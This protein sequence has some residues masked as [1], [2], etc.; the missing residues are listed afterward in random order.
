MPRKSKKSEKALEQEAIPQTETA[1][2]EATPEVSATAIEDPIGDTTDGEA[3]VY[4][5]E[6]E[7]ATEEV[8]EAL[9][10]EPAED[11]EIES[12]ADEEDGDATESGANG[13]GDPGADA[14]LGDRSG[15]Q[16]KGAEGEAED[17]GDGEDTVAAEFGLQ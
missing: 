4:L 10:D 11:A 14:H 17:A 15:D 7:P 8:A 6:T 1:E 16:G 12:D 5:G 9:P 2:T 3:R 13:K